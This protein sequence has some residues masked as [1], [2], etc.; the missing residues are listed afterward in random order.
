METH[1]EMAELKKNRETAQITNSATQ[2][3]E[4]PGKISVLCFQYH[5][6]VYQSVKV[7]SA[8]FRQ[9]GW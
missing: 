5:C 4:L 2:Q 7:G 6:T 8:F 9:T 1:F 3:E